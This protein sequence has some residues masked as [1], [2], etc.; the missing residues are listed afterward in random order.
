M[1]ISNNL[2]IWNAKVR[3]G[4]KAVI[5][6]LLMQQIVCLENQAWEA[7]IGFIIYWG[8]SKKKISYL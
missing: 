3:G 6:L 1:S 4:E 8:T 2:Y 7:L 5:S